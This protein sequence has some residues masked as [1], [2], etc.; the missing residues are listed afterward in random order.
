MRSIHYI[1]IG[2]ILASCAE[3]LA[4]NY[5]YRLHL[6]GKPGSEP[7][8]LS[9]R[10]QERRARYGIVADSLDLEI[11]PGYIEQIEAAGLVV[12]TRSHWLN[13]VVV[14]GKDGASVPASLF[15]SL[16]FV[17]KVETIITT[18]RA[19]SPVRLTAQSHVAADGENCTSPLKQVNAYE[20]LYMAGHR[21]AGMLV[22]ILD[23]GFTRVDQWEWLNS[24]V[25]GTRDLY[26][27][28]T[29]TSHI[30][31]GDMHGS[32]CLSIMASPEEHGICGT[33]QEADYCLMRTETDDSET[34]L[35]E[36]MWVAAAELADSLG[37]DV[38][39]SS[40]GYYDFDVEESSHTYD[41]FGQDRVC[42][43]RGAKVACQKGILVVNAA[44]NERN[45]YWNSL[46]FPADVEEVLAVG[47]VTPS[48]RLASF[49]SPGFTVPYVKPDVVGR[50]T[51]CYVIDYRGG[52][53]T[54][55]SGTSYATP[56]IAG[57]CTSLW[58]A[59]PELSAA[60]IRQVVRESASQYSQPDS[61]M[62]YGLPDFG[63]ALTKA[64]QWVE[65]MGIEEVKAETPLR[66]T[67]I[68]NLQGQ[69]CANRPRQGIFIENGRLK[70]LR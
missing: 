25:V 15:E 14:M 55:G 67:G 50:G 10:A 53:D 43:S 60:Q 21:G 52:V 47:A 49:S 11:S 30:Y 46:I 9:E 38:I 48:N 13:T 57:L 3:A 40:L 27:P 51:R 12:V 59:V 8:K 32:C 56:L 33:A 16:P 1:I 39:S 64:R 65:E 69:R 23:A 37:V 54:Y 24:R 61:L 58:S 19:T 7:V 22:A 18:Q 68:F 6:D 29:G 4:D 5:R 42:I 70:F 41:D 35:E 20:P 44:G 66:S 31:D 62:G 17:S 34:Q 26:Q 2:A 36:D 63:L 45:N 28:T